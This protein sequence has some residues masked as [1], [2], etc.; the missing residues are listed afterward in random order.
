MPKR[1]FFC[2]TPWDRFLLYEFVKPLSESKENCSTYNNLCQQL[3]QIY[4]L[5]LWEELSLCACYETF[6][7]CF[8]F[9]P[10]GSWIGTQLLCDTA[11]FVDM[12]HICLQLSPFQ[13]ISSNMLTCSSFCIYVIYCPSLNF[14]DILVDMK[15]SELHIFQALDEL[16]HP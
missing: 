10:P 3:P 14:V 16:C 1:N 11:G 12:Y 2:L 9:M 7:Y 4:L 13:I 15:E 6:S 5:H 8:Y